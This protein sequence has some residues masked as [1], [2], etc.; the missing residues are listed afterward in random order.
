MGV[1]YHAYDTL[2]R[3]DVAV[4]TIYDVPSSIFL[5][6]FNRECSV[7]ASLVHPNIVEVFD[8]GEFEQ[9][10][11]SKPYFVMPLLPGRTLYDLI[12]PAGLPLEVS[13]CV[14]IIG[15]CCRALQAA[16]ERNLLH[17]DIKPR[18]IFVM[19]D[20][21]VKLIDF[22]IAHVLGN[23]STMV[24]GTPQYM[25]PEQISMR[26]L[27]PQSDIFSL[28]TVCYEALTGV[29]PFVKNGDS[30]EADGGIAVAITTYNPPPACE[31][32]PSITRSVAQAVAKGMAKEPWAR[33]DSASSFANALLRASR[34]NSAVTLPEYG[35]SAR[36][37]RARKAFAQ[38]D[39]AFTAELVRQLEAEG[40]ADDQVKQLRRE[41]DEALRRQRTEQLLDTAKRFQES[42]E[43]TL[44]LRKVQEVLE[45]DPAN[46]TAL[47]LKKQIERQ[48]SE[49]KFNELLRLAAEYLQ[50]AAFTNARQAAQEAMKL[51]PNDA[52][53][54]QLLVEV[55][56][57]QKELLR[58]R[59]EQE[60][61]F[62][63]A[64][65]AWL[66][67][68]IQGAIDRL[69]E[70]DELCAGQTDRKERI[71]EY[72]DF[73]QR[74]RADFDAL[75]ATVRDARGLIAAKDLN[76]AKKLC[77]R[78]IAKYPGNPSLLAL[79]ADIA[80][81]VEQE[82][83]AYRQGVAKQ[84]EE[85]P[86]LAKQVSILAHE[87]KKNPQEA[88]FRD[89]LA[90]VRQ[91][92]EAVTAEERNALNAERR[93]QLE[94]A[95]EGWNAIGRLH[96]KFPGL[97]DNLAR[98]QRAIQTRDAEIRLRAITQIS[99]ALKDEDFGQATALLSQARIAY[100]ND[101]E[102]ERLSDQLNGCIQQQ[103]TV[104]SL[105]LQANSLQADK[106]L[107][108][109]RTR[110][111]EAARLSTGSRKLQERVFAAAVQ[112]ARRFAPADW[113]E[114]KQV[115]QGLVD[116][117]LGTKVP[118][119]AWE[120]VQK[121][122]TESRILRT[123][124]QASFFEGAGDL[125]QAQQVLTEAAKTLGT[126]PRLRTRMATVE[127][128]VR[129][130]RQ[131]EERDSCFERLRALRTNW[132]QTEHPADSNMFLA[133]LDAL[134]Q[135]CAKDH[136]LQG[137]ADELRRDV[138]AYGEAAALLDKDQLEESRR[139]CREAL[140][141]TPGQQPFQL[142]G[143]LIDL[144]HR[145]ISSRFAEQIRAD[146]SK[147]PNLDRRAEIL[148]RALS[149]YP[150]EPIFQR[151]LDLI[152]TDQNVIATTAAS[153][154]R[155][156]GQGEFS[157]AAA[158]WQRIQ[159]IHPFYP[160]IEDAV[161]RCTKAALQKEQNAI[162]AAVK[163]IES[164]LAKRDYALSWQ[165]L[166]GAIREF[167]AE[168]RLLS[169]KNR[170]LEIQRRRS[171]AEQLISKAQQECDA[172][173]FDTGKKRLEEALTIA[174]GEQDLVEAIATS[175]FKQARAAVDSNWKLAEQMAEA[176]SA[177]LAGKGA[178][179]DLRASIAAASKREQTTKALREVKDAED[180]GN[181]AKA[182]AL[183]RKLAAENPQ[184]REITATE[185]R[186][187]RKQEEANAREQKRQDLARLS[188]YENRARSAPD[189]HIC[190]ELLSQV[191]EIAARYTNDKDTAARARTLRE[192]LAAIRDIRR[193]LQSGEIEKAQ[194]LQMLSA[195]KHP[196]VPAFLVLASEV[197]TRAAELAAEYPHKVETKLE[198]EPNFQKQRAILEDAVRAYPDEPFFQTELQLV[199]GKQS[200]LNASIARAKEL[201]VRQ[202]HEDALREFQ[203]LSRRHPW[204]PELKADV[205][206]VSNAVTNR[207]LEKRKQQAAGV[208]GA[209]A[210][211]DIDE[212]ERLLL[213][214]EPDQA[215]VRTLRVK[216][217]DA[218]R[219][220]KDSRQRFEILNR[221]LSD[222]TADQIIAAAN[223]MAALPALNVGV[224]EAAVKLLLERA[225]QEVESRWQFA[226]QVLAA[227]RRLD[228]QVEVPSQLTGRIAEGRRELERQTW[229]DEA[230]KAEAGSDWNAVR[231][232]CNR[233]LNRFPADREFTTR[234]ERA[235]DELR[236][237]ER[238]HLRNEALDKI[239]HLRGRLP[240]VARK[241]R[242]L[243]A[244]R[245]AIPGESL[246]SEDSQVKAA[247]SQLVDDITAELKALEARPLP[248]VRSASIGQPVM[249]RP[250][251]PRKPVII[252]ASAA[253]VLAAIGAGYWFTHKSS[254]SGTDL[255][256]MALPSTVHV[257]SDVTEG[258]IALDGKASDKG[259]GG[260]LKLDGTSPGKHTLRI[261]GSGGEAQLSFTASRD[262]I[263]L[264]DASGHNLNV[265]AVSQAAG[266][267]LV[268]TNVQG[269][270][271]IDGHQ[272]GNGGGPAVG[273]PA[274]QAGAHH[275]EIGSRGEKV[276][277]DL[278][279]DSPHF[280]DVFVS[281]RENVGALTVTANVSNFDLI[282]NGTDHRIGGKTSRLRLPAGEYKIGAV[283]E[284]Y[285]P[286]NPTRVTVTKASDT[287]LSIQLVAKP[288]T[289]EFVG[290]Q[291]GTNVS[292]D[293][294]S[295]GT[296]P[297]NGRLSHELDPG[298]HTLQLAKNG[299]NSKAI[300][301]R[302]EPGQK[303]RI[304]ASELQLTPVTLDPAAVDDQQWAAA[305][306]SP[307]LDS[308]QTYLLNNAN[309]RHKTEA[310][311]KM[312]DFAWN[313]LNQSDPKS[314]QG[315]LDKFGD[316]G[317]HA[318]QARV[319]IK[320]LNEQ[321][322]WTAVDKTSDSSLQ[323]FL[324]K[325]PD[326]K[327]AA[328]A[329]RAINELKGQKAL[330]GERS[331]D[332]AW[333]KVDQSNPDS[334]N[335]YVSNFPSGKHRHDAKLAMQKIE[336]Q[337]LPAEVMAAVSSRLRQY[338]HAWASKRVNEILNVNPALNGKTLKNELAS[339]KSIN[340]HF[341]SC[342]APVINGDQASVMCQRTVEE[343]LVTGQ[344]VQTPA[345]PVQINAARR[346]G[347]WVIL[348]IGG[349]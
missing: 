29:Q 171:E 238:E 24:R 316:Q 70:L 211:G 27:T 92:H 286:M 20:D 163:D 13:R 60:R 195:E 15:Q 42:D 151:D 1:V 176:G 17:R 153:A 97:A 14:D 149:V 207:L 225:T 114:A 30:R 348:S 296:I 249:E 16:H 190:S 304:G 38:N 35:I 209:L 257:L 134:K 251:T 258:Q 242:K 11:Y 165:V 102:I 169:V 3:R 189:V 87:S 219:I 6:F 297:Q 2:M 108:D 72:K 322:E 58:R 9:D 175:F 86:S 313:G 248:K 284:G 37:H 116:L 246:K 119:D 76:G 79:A 196:E 105:L 240:A 179:Q 125:M 295:I 260:E 342:A 280:L 142:L 10:G 132:N 252:G 154:R 40:Y 303:R 68:N 12:Y 200:L 318:A 162:A 205:E 261:T 271:T 314:L 220:L 266:S 133:S 147:E 18:N 46:D 34:D 81:T 26:G 231:N 228:P 66:E 158:T 167:P 107:A 273:V 93:G 106:K 192:V 332:N 152:R 288:S 23:N 187:N 161:A 283:R 50:R 344:K 338:E 182:L 130:K 329:Q 123:L 349:S 141:R 340:M 215:D 57:R 168:S 4:K 319:L 43:L 250:P 74:V 326:S 138:S 5:D 143:P 339:A 298:V 25:S 77:D 347:S 181:L 75:Q 170:L 218:K 183:I 323:D 324:T 289:L 203:E 337:A 302:A 234:L 67:G 94:R 99:A 178:P 52:K 274:L 230:A 208:E 191:E 100:P 264:G 127:S 331:D 270:V 327:Y 59:Q 126:D 131:R 328:D 193:S 335:T 217:D 128:L 48:V 188:E 307:S 253:V 136:E 233:A 120:E 98:V 145:D 91:K 194:R 115:L 222:G 320:N 122:E 7:L 69:A 117:N 293:N 101:A 32:N 275:I 290:G 28:A 229:V 103:S 157:D 112:S 44:A 247:A 85:E 140:S 80:A 321:A 245:D 89:T 39:Y 237:L 278:K 214:S 63:V 255:K 173:Q 197:A 317:H 199:D 334:I 139:V 276:G 265:V 113:R 21:A 292:I 325:H 223:E 96:P 186:L 306:S 55:D 64:Q 281:G 272:V 198:Q 8:M 177:A 129:E 224:R 110:L 148:E 277:F 269:N 118:V 73:E 160:Q 212:A 109:A 259:T 150:E 104:S 159:A 155:L 299:F 36:L 144:R 291:P 254:G 111:L 166:N 279:V 41:L 309:G 51:R 308:M 262:G 232:A 174:A 33:F 345:T 213:E 282:V 221:A 90:A 156:E 216:V 88:F 256:S 124:E 312:A 201:E 243:V 268:G 346:G 31:L 121:Y 54:K 184:E 311:E 164:A 333:A 45:Y 172:K 227:M 56:T 301:I 135:T 287:G 285:V 53:A 84:I 146:L 206:R 343:V 267:A 83:A 202:F 310:R 61:L 65:A 241:K 204:L 19:Q 71:A 294:N 341:G 95:V 78:S 315:Y 236:R 210:A 244:L 185:E 49:Q 180:G 305:N 82:A 330:A 300:Q 137:F 239:T 336:Q 226:D 263:T 22:G 47:A 62:Q 235:D